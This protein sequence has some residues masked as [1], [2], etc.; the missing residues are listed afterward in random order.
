MQKLDVGSCE[1][2]SKTF[3][4]YLIHSGFNDS[5]YAYCDHCGMT[6]IRSVYGKRMP[7]L[8]LNGLPFEEICSELES[9]LLPCQCGGPF[10]KGASPRC[11]HCSEPL[12][13][14]A[15]AGY[16]ETNALGTKTGWHWQRNWR[17]LYCIVIENMAVSDNFKT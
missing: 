4:Y 3:G 1:H 12:S 2:C 8:A 16:I 7:K 10:K 5:S 6:A 13:P 15:A 17:S 11:P 9:Y 14:D